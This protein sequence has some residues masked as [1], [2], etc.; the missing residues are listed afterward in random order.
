MGFSTKHCVCVCVC[1][2]PLNSNPNNGFKINKQSTLPP[3]SSTFPP[4]IVLNF[5][6][7]SLCTYYAH[8][9]VDSKEINFTKLAGTWKCVLSHNR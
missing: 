1:V 6:S 9:R 4:T 2:L 8:F 5:N 3:K 7:Y